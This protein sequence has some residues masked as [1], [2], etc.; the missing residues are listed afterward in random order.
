MQLVPTETFSKNCP[1]LAKGDI[2]IRGTN[3]D[4][5]NGSYGCY[6]QREGPEKNFLQSK[7]Q[8][9]L[10]FCTVQLSFNISFI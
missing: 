10:F 1:V 5:F 9:N 6:N 4:F 2:F 3:C 8:F 7:Y